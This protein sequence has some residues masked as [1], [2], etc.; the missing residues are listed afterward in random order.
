[1]LTKALRIEGSL[2]PQMPYQAR[3]RWWRRLRVSVRGL[4]IIVLVIGGWLGW[5]VSGARV[6]RDAVAAIENAGGKAMYNWQFNREKYVAA[7]KP[8]APRRIVDLIGI[9]Y[10]SHVTSVAIYS[11]RKA[12]ADVTMS[13]VGR[14]SGLQKLTV[15]TISLTDVGMEHLAGL[16]ELS[17]LAIDNTRVSDAGMA[18]LAGLTQ[19][20]VLDLANTQVSSA[21]LVHLRRL[22]NLSN[23]DLRST[24]VSDT[25]LGH[26][27]ELRNLKAVH[28]ASTQV[29]DSG[30]VQLK[31]L[32]GLKYLNLRGTQVSDAGIIHLEGLT[33]LIELNIDKTR[34][35]K[36]GVQ[37]LQRA[38]PNL[39][40]HHP[41]AAE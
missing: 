14:L 12:K 3:T 9:D 37:S 7:G 21:G 1:M 30:L 32:S 19:L 22:I 15:E 36:S 11:T 4:I 38:L 2:G 6:Q 20:T 23:L 33:H 40:I 29:T 5:I 35:T 34:V 41:L 8:W 28:L 25:G 17:H 26:L 10:F 16:S 39:K 13:H 24:R 31:R 27:G 18:H